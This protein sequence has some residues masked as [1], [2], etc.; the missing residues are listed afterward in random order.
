MAAD[1]LVLAIE[2][3]GYHIDRRSRPHGNRFQR[4]ERLVTMA[5]SSSPRSHRQAWKQM[6]TTSTR[7]P[8]AWMSKA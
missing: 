8:S 6:S 1:A 4:A 5:S 7:P 2:L 3:A